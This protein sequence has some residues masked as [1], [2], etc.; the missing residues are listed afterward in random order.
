MS[1]RRRRCA[2]RR[3]RRRRET[4]S[5]LPRARHLERLV[6]V[7]TAPAV[8]LR[9]QPLRLLAVHCLAATL[10]TH[11]NVAAATVVST[12]QY[13]ERLGAHAARGLAGERVVRRP[14]ASASRRRARA[15]RSGRGRRA[16]DPSM[17]RAVHGDRE[18]AGI[19]CR[20]R[21]AQRAKSSVAGPVC[22]LTRH[23]GNTCRTGL[24]RD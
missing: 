4:P 7:Q 8:P 17:A 16:T 6:C 14:V 19:M 10:F 9:P 23:A 24:L 11:S 22:S 3:H 2:Q 12:P 1:R 21:W 13:V 15:R 18:A 20:S 5:L